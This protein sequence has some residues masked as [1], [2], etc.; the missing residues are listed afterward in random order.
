M[1]CGRT[2]AALCRRSQPWGGNPF[3]DAGG[4]IGLT[5]FPQQRLSFLP[6]RF[7]FG[8]LSEP[9]G[10]VFRSV[11]KSQDSPETA[12]L[13]GAAPC[14]HWAGAQLAFSSPIKAMAAR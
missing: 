11:W 12:T 14:L 4:R 7:T 10:F 2:D 6:G 13:H 1:R 9:C 3:I 5:G 8:F